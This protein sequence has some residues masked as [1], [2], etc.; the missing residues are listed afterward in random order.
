ML[1]ARP[2]QK[3]LGMKEK[4][5]V[6][7]GTLEMYSDGELHGNVPAINSLVLLD[8]LIAELESDELVRTIKTSNTNKDVLIDAED[9]PILSRYTWSENVH[10]YAITG[11][12]EKYTIMHR[13]IVNPPSVVM[14]DHRI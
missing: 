14:F 10:G 13:M 7:R 8:T 3:E 4:L 9:W 1:R 5:E 6:I 2:L 12:N 11:G